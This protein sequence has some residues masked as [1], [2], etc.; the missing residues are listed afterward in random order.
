M[1]KQRHWPELS[2]Q[3]T[4]YQSKGWPAA[5]QVLTARGAVPGSVVREAVGVVLA[6]GTGAIRRS[7]QHSDK[8]EAT[9]VAG[10]FLPLDR[11]AYI[12]MVTNMGSK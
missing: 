4:T 2:P 6:V 8:C 11:R 10:L 1:L 12:D 5:V 9:S 7:N 3:R